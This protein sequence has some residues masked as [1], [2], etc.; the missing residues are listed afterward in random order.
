LVASGHRGATTNRTRMAN[1]P[2][3]ERREQFIT[4]AVGVISEVGVQ[5][6]TT[7][8]IAEAAQAPLA[9][10]HY[11]FQSKD[12]LLLDVFDRILAS[13]RADT[14]SLDGRGRSVADVAAQLLTRTLEWGLHHPDEARAEFDLALWASRQE[15]GVGVEMYAGFSDMWT[16][17][18][19]QADP[20]LTPA[21]LASTVRLIMALADG[22]GL[23]MLAKDDPG[24]TRSDTAEA[25]AML[26]AHLRSDQS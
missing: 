21:E 25:A 1:I 19:R 26:A 23:Q 20:A 8:R 12:R 4:A 7:R 10:L 14:A 22:L 17:L 18:L 11:C 15:T 9:A 5:G 24:Q 13:H 2:A 3:G 16:D 6:A